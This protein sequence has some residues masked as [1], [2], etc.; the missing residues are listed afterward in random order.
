MNRP[1]RFR[2]SL[3]GMLVAMVSAAFAHSALANTGHVDFT[4]GNVNLT[5][6]NGRVQP[7]KKGDEV[8]SGDRIVSGVDGRTQIR[9]SDGAYVSLQPNSDFDIK[10]YRFDGK[11]DGTESAVFSLFKGALRTVTGLVGRV[12]RNKYSI[13]TP[14]ATIGIRGTGGVISVGADGSTLV[15]GTSGIWTLSNNGGTLEIPAGSSGFA[16]NPNLPPKQ[17]TT[18]PTIPPA[19]PPQQAA[20]FVQGDTKT[21]TG[22]PASLFTPLTSGPGYSVGVGDGGVG[23]NASVPFGAPLPASAVFDASGQLIKLTADLD[24]PAF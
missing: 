14:T 17:S 3:R 15:T 1:K 8:R 13:T 23:S 2:L 12:N 6:A 7:L 16:G 18:G 19:Q 24:G 10:E 21:G 9:F 5:D 20:T 22:G 11:T 4:I